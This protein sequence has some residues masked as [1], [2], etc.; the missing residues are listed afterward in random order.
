MICFV[1]D[2]DILTEDLKFIL[3]LEVPYANILIHRTCWRDIKDD[4]IS[5]FSQFSVEDV[6]MK[7]EEINKNMKVNDK[8]KTKRNII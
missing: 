5:Y 3:P 7:L 8:S 2:K 6:I 1:C 4:L